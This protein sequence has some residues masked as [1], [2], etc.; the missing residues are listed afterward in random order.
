[1]G[2][3]LQEIA[4]RAAADRLARVHSPAQARRRPAGAA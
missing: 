3:E 1:M 4:E 2:A